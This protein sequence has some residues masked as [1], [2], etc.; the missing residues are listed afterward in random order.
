MSRHTELQ[1]IEK[2]LIE[3]RDLFIRISTLVMEQQD[4]VNRIEDFNTQTKARVAKVEKTLDK[5]RKLKLKVLKVKGILKTKTKCQTISFVTRISE[6]DVALDMDYRDFIG[7]HL[8]N[9]H[10]TVVTNGTQYVQA[11]ED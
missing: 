8:N 5:A 11:Q 6:K 4:V 7:Y 3:V 1:K 9:G 10:S 2:A